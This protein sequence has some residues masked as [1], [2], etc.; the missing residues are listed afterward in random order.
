MASGKRSGA[1]SPSTC[2]PNP[3]VPK[4]LPLRPRVPPAVPWARSPVD[5]R[6]SRAAASGSASVGGCRHED[7]ARPP[8]AASPALSRL[9]AFCASI[10]DRRCPSYT[11]SRSLRTSTSSGWLSLSYA[12][13]CAWVS[14]IAR[15]RGRAGTR[16][17][18]THL[19]DA[20]HSPVVEVVQVAR[21]KGNLLLYRVQHA[22]VDVVEQLHAIDRIRAQHGARHLQH[23][24]PAV[25]Q[26]D[27]RFPKV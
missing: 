13:A 19:G 7:C 8:S 26:A 9:V 5:T 22:R 15:A 20:I 21:A 11:A 3:S 12:S 2:S 17:T 6:L 25:L 18:R 16:R 23:P 1:S 10:E 27:A 4:M 24:S 14:E